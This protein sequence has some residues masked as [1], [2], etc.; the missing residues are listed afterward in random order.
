MDKFNQLY[1]Q[2]NADQ[3]Q[4]YLNGVENGDYG[5]SLYASFYAPLLTETQA[6]QDAFDEKQN[7]NLLTLTI[8]AYVVGIMS[9]VGVLFVVN[10]FFF[11]ESWDWRHKAV[12]GFAYALLLM[13][14][15]TVLGYAAAE[16]NNLRKVAD[17]DTRLTVLT[18]ANFQEDVYTKL[19]YE[20]AKFMTFWSAYGRSASNVEQLQL[21]TTKNTTEQQLTTLQAMYPVATDADIATYRRNMQFHAQNIVD[22]N[23]H[24]LDFKSSRKAKLNKVILYGCVLTPLLVGGV[25]GLLLL[26]AMQH[27]D[28]LLGTYFTSMKPQ[29]MLFAALAFAVV[30]IFETMAVYFITTKINTVSEVVCTTVP[31]SFGDDASIA[32]F[33]S[34]FCALQYVYPDLTNVASPS[35]AYMYAAGVVTLAIGIMFLV[36]FVYCL[37]GIL[38]DTF[39]TKKTNPCT[40]MEEGTAKKLPL[41]YTVI[42]LIMVVIGWGSNFLT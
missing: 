19:D 26:L 41:L 34:E 28:L 15:T 2:Y 35:V 38:P 27:G 8:S 6:I 31:S 20:S 22:L 17:T 42:L 39:F 4:G 36:T 12:V 25:F 33:Y 16:Y 3:Y 1:K 37:V 11:N 5:A 23:V 10:G 24:S 9:I 32:R 13:V 14:G 30:M 29:L 7:N 40:M 21:L 18:Y